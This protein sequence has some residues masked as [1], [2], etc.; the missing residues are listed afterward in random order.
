MATCLA[1]TALIAPGSASADVGN[2][3]N[4]H[5]A[6]VQIKT[7]AMGLDNLL[8]EVGSGTGVIVTPDGVVLTNHHVVTVEDSFD[9][10]E[11]PVGYQ[12]CLTLS[13]EL[14]PDCSYTAKLIAKDKD[15]DLAL[16]KIVP[17]SGLS[18][19]RTFTYLEALRSDTVALNDEVAILGYPAIGGDTISASA[20]IVSGKQDKYGKKWI[21]SDAVVSFGSSGGA[22]LD[23][24]GKLVGIPTEVHSDFAG[25]LGYAINVSSIRSWIDSNVSGNPTAAPLQ[26]QVEAMAKKQK[27]A[28]D[29][30]T[31]T[32][33]TGAFSVT[34]PSDWEFEYLHEDSLF[35]GK[36]SDEEAGYVVIALAKYPFNVSLNDA[37]LVIKSQLSTSQTLATVQITKS[38]EATINGVKS[39]LIQSSALGSIT[40]QYFIPNRNYFIQVVYGNG[41]N[42]R[43][44]AIVRGIVNSI[45]TGSVPQVTPLQEYTNVRPVF[46]LRTTSDWALN[47][48]NSKSGPINFHH[49]SKLGLADVSLMKRSED[50]RAMS[51]EQFLEQIVSSHNSLNAITGNLNLRSE[52]VQSSAHAVLNDEI[53]DGVMVQGKSLNI[54]TGQVVQRDYSFAIPTPDAWIVLSVGYFG[55]DEAGYNAVLDSFRPILQSFSLS[56]KPRAAT[57]AVAT[58]AAK[59]QATAAPV[60]RTGSLANRMKGKILL[61]VE[62]RGEAWYVK[63]EDGRRVYMKD[64][65]TAYQMMRSLGTGISNADLEKI[66]VGVE[67]RF[68]DADQDGDG[69]ADKLEEG[70]KTD[71][72]NPDTDGDGV[73]DGVEVLTNGTNPLG[74]GRLTISSSLVNRM[75]GKIL[76]QVESRGEAWYVRPEDGKRYYMKDGDAAYQIM[77]FLST[78]IRNSDLDQIAAAE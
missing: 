52:I 51:N 72:T 37:D 39:R 31:F 38:E 11:W 64:G 60:A 22:V 54:A 20:G 32:H 69:L 49:R 47:P 45:R 5:Q 48:V 8:T 42:D 16:L 14:E 26:T 74:S 61:Q 43:D 68:T 78:G 4:A 15:S 53:K 30:N 10:S 66:P 77:R 13:Y 75:L 73:S 17:I 12:V 50:Q 56:S 25:S 9:D 29:S 7:F 21:K 28:N 40:N 33:D 24:D 57:A 23:A 70:L 3:N 44:S 76:L 62:S 18:I 65:A 58:P 2:I 34:K 63:P 6:I 19:S 55:P 71:P 67:T 27:S 59:P 41:K 46:S 36:L 1:T 35:I